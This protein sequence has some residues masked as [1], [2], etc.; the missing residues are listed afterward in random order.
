MLRSR[1]LPLLGTLAIGFGLL[2]LRAGADMLFGDGA[3]HAGPVVPFVL[4]FNFLAGFAYVASGVGLVLRT[5]WGE[6]GAV[7]LAI[8][9]LAAFAVFGVH[10][11]QG[12]AYAART[13][14]A[15]TI[16]AAFW[17]AVALIARSALRAH[18]E[19]AP[20]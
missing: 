11:A 19:G 5:R 10:V 9:T 6:R 3:S 14:S 7:V 12:G 4:W 18:P 8:A 2:T 1:V 13:V 20:R 16:R 15:L 17:I